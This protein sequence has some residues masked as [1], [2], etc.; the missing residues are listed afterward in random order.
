M[1]GFYQP[2]FVSQDTLVFLEGFRNQES[3]LI[4]DETDPILIGMGSALTKFGNL[5][6]AYR[7]IFPVNDRAIFSDI[8]AFINTIGSR[9][10]KD[11]PQSSLEL[12]QKAVER[13]RHQNSSRSEVESWARHLAKKLSPSDE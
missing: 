1:E 12:A 5:V 3:E 2:A 11:V 9:S 6:L 7:D 13:A 4:Y 10:A 8:D